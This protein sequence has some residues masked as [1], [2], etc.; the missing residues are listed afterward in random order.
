MNR[1]RTFVLLTV[2][3]IAACETNSVAPDEASLRR[4]VSNR[5]ETQLSVDRTDVTPGEE[6]IATYSI[7]NTRAESVRLESSCTA[8]AKGVVYRNSQ[9][10]EFVG[11]GSGC[12][13]AIGVHEIAAGEAIE[14][15]WKVKAAVVLWVYPDGR[16]DIALAEPDQYLF[17]VEPDVF[18]ISEADAQLPALDLR[19]DV[20]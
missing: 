8:I 12:Y 1:K 9:E 14:W 11:S 4:A 17:R 15:Q 6:F 10:V 13:P 20:K 5:L 19:V 3:G 2:V 7:R 16:Q 18:R